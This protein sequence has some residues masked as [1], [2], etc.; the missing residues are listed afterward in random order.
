LDH[1]ETEQESQFDT[2]AILDR[3]T[4]TTA[5]V[6]RLVYPAF[7]L[8]RGAGCK[9][10]DHAFWDLQTYLGLRE[11]LAANEGTRSFVHES[12]QERTPLGHAHRDHVRELSVEQIRAM[13]RQAIRRLI[14]EVAET[15]K[16]FRAG[17]VAIDITEAPPLTGDRTGH[18]DGIIGTKEQTNEY[19]YR[20]ATVQ[21]VENAVPLVLDA[22]PVLKGES[23]DCK[24]EAHG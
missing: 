18:E 14:D 1:P 2:Q 3:A 13:Y 15:E 7:S 6:G 16:F 11:R 20:W 17:I 19:A 10:H 21:L 4:E 23:H 8:D 22:R 12:T 9:I 5:Q 24:E